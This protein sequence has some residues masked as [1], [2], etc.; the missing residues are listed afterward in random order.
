MKL[1]QLFLQNF[2]AND[3]ACQKILVAVSTGLDSMVLLN[4]L[5]NLPMTVRPQITVAYVDHQLRKQSAKET[6]FIKEY[7]QKNNLSLVCKSWPKKEHPVSG[8]EESARQMRYAFFA[9]VMENQGLD[10]LLTAHH[11]DDQAETWLMKLIRGGRL[12]QLE[13]IKVNRA[14]ANKRLV[15]LLL[16]FSKQQLLEYAKQK[17]L[18]WF[19]DE[20]NQDQC[21]LRNRM[22][23]QVVPLLKKENPAF[24]KHINEYCEQLNDLLA[25]KQQLYRQLQND[26]QI[27]EGYCLTSWLKL[28]QLQQKLFIEE[29]IMQTTKS[30][31]TGQSQAVLSLLSNQSKPQGQVNLTTH[32]MLVKSY[33]YFTIKEKLV[34]TKAK[35]VAKELVLGEWIRLNQFESIG[36]F[37]KDKQPKGNDYLNI[38]TTAKRLFVRHR[39]AGDRLLMKNGRQK[40]KK[41]FIDH[42]LTNEQR[43]DAWLVSDEQQKVYWVI[44]L[45]K[46]DLSQTPRDAKM[47]YV[48]VY[49]DKRK[50]D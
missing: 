22:R 47:Q 19:E 44:G 11:A 7:C 36:L 34:K 8:I 39:L 12:E 37:E 17:G 20:T 4:L 2:Q 29:L 15:R 42:K 43:Q 33:D 3:L 27:K 1:E 40:I 49:T 41:I 9:E 6:I 31:T 23:Q 38:T 50:E 26:L 13:A 24:L 25:I 48:I 35:F 16:P 46:S 28:S 30:L 5:Q 18:R 45:K 32:Y 10:A 14:F 21:Y